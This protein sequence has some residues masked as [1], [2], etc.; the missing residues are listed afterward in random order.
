MPPSGPSRLGAHKSWGSRAGRIPGAVDLLAYSEDASQL[1]GVVGHH[2]T[3]LALLDGSPQDRPEKPSAPSASLQRLDLLD[4][5]L[6]RQRSVALANHEA[7]AKSGGGGAFFEGAETPEEEGDDLLFGILPGGESYLVGLLVP[8]A[9][10]HLSLEVGSL[11]AMI[12]RSTADGADKW[13]TAAAPCDLAAQAQL[14]LGVSPG[15][16][17]SQLILYDFDGN[18][19]VELTQPGP[20]PVVCA[21]VSADGQKL[22]CRQRGG[23]YTLWDVEKKE[24]LKQWEDLEASHAEVVPDT[25]WLDVARLSADGTTAYVADRDSRSVVALSLPE[26]SVKWR[27]TGL[28]EPHLALSPDGKQLAVTHAPTADLSTV[29][30]LEA[31]TGARRTLAM[32]PGAEVGCVAV[33]PDGKLAV[34]GDWLGELWASDVEGRRFVWSCQAASGSISEIEFAPD[35]KT[36]YAASAD[37]HLVRIEASS[38]RELARFKSSRTPEEKGEWVL[39]MSLSEDGGALLTLHNAEGQGVVCLWDDRGG[40]RWRT[41][42]KSLGAPPKFVPSACLLAGGVAYV[43]GHTFHPPHASL[44][45]LDM[46][47]GQP[48]RTSVLQSLVAMIHKPAPALLPLTSLETLVH[49]PQGPLAIGTGLEGDLAVVAVSNAEKQQGLRGLEGQVRALAISGD[50]KQLLSAY[51]KL[52]AKRLKLFDLAT[53]DTLDETGIESLHDEIGAFTFLPDFSILLVTSHGLFHHYLPAP[54]DTGKA[55]AG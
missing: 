8:R 49:S 6:A 42:L 21:A 34:S 26:G 45:A 3:R 50:G 28:V 36:L 47:T 40:L 19:K 9:M 12:L 14:I 48:R 52:D 32:G 25:W 43:G 11:P 54:E 55:K 38:G 17:R 53:G 20:G 2:S 51:P 35:G 18:A 7:I 4:S 41:S 15:V 23:R 31:E 37:G 13:R 16:A 24:I 1:L 33:S 5:L 27:A 44:F 39:A 30:L 46:A 22:L 29:M 10:R